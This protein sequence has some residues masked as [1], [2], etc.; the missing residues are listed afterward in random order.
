MKVLLGAIQHRRRAAAELGLDARDAPR[1]IIVEFGSLGLQEVFLELLDGDASLMIVA[2]PHEVVATEGDDPLD[3]I[4]QDRGV[5]SCE[6]CPMATWT[7]GRRRMRARS[8][9][10]AVSSL[11]NPPG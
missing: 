2:R 8:G 4:S 9:S 5:R 10:R 7:S 1:L 11:S 6:K 3:G